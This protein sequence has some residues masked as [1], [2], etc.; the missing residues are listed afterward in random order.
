MGLP[1]PHLHVFLPNRPPWRS[2]PHALNPSW[3]GSFG[4]WG[5]PTTLAASPVWC[6]TVALMA[7]LSQW[8]PPARSTALRTS[9]G[10]AGSCTS[11]SGCLLF[12]SFSSLVHVP[13]PASPV[14]RPCHALFSLTSISSQHPRPYRWPFPFP[15]TSHLLWAPLLL[16]SSPGA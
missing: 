8:M 13:V 16:P 14:S 15:P 2:V 9:T 10:Q 6:A 4:L 5:R 11:V 3:T 1:A 7:S 12:P